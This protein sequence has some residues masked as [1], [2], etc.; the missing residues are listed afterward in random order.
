L[1]AGSCGLA[2]DNS[3]FAP[4]LLAVCLLLLTTSLPGFGAVTLVYV[5]TNGA[6]SGTGATI[7]APVSLPRAQARVRELNTTMS[8]DIKVQLLPGT[9]PITT[10]LTFNEN[11]S[12]SN[13]FNV[14]WCAQDTNNPPILSGGTNVTG[15]S[16]VAGTSNLW[17]APVTTTAFRQ[18][19]LNG[20]RRQR[21]QSC[22]PI[23]VRQ[24]ILN[25]NNTTRVLLVD[26]ATLPASLTAPGRAEIHVVNDWRDY[27]VALTAA[28]PTNDSRYEYA[29][30]ALIAPGSQWGDSG[31]QVFAAPNLAHACYLENA[32][33]LLDVP[34]EW[35][36]DAVSNRLYYMA[37]PGEDLTTAQ[38]VIPLVQALLNVQGSRSTKLVHNIEF[39]GLC[40]EY[41]TWTAV[42]NAGFV[43]IQGPEIQR[44]FV[45]FTPGGIQVENAAFFAFRNCRF[46]HLGATA[47]YCI[48]YVSDATI[49]GNAFTD[50]AGCGLQ[51]GTHYLS[52]A[53][54]LPIR[55][56]IADNLFYRVGRDYRGSQA[57]VAYSLRD[58]TFT[59]NHIEDVPYSGIQLGDF[60][61]NGGGY[62]NTKAIND[63]GNNLLGSNSVRNF[64]N[65]C[66]D[67]GAFYING[68]QN[69]SD[70]VQRTSLVTDNVFQEA[71]IDEGAL[72]SEDDSGNITYQRNVCEQSLNI[73][74]ND[75]I[76]WLYA[77]SPNSYNLHFGAG[78]N[79]NYA[80]TNMPG[81][82][83]PSDKNVPGHGYVAPTLYASP[84]ARPSAAAAIVAAA[85]L[86]PA[87]T[88][89]LAL[90]ANTNGNTAPTVLGL[91]NLTCDLSQTL[92][93]APT[94]SDDGLP[95]DR[96][97]TT[98]SE[99]SGPGNVT[100]SSLSLSATRVAFSAAGTYVLNFEVTDGALATNARFS[101]VVAPFTFGSNVVAG[102]LPTV[103]ASYFSDWN[104]A[105]VTDGSFSTD[106][107]TGIWFSGYGVG[108]NPWVQLDAGRAVSPCR[109]VLGARNGNADERGNFQI[110]AAN[111]PDFTNYVILAE[112]GLDPYGNMARWVANVSTTNSFRYFRAQSGNG[113][114]S[115][116]EFQV[117]ERAK[118]APP[119]LAIQTVGPSLQLTWSKGALLEATN[120]A[121]PWTTNTS[122]SPYLIAPNSPAKFYRIRWP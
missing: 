16:L 7:G 38:V 49:V 22:L 39:N 71:W 11:D 85:G 113:E 99:A 95:F 121:G 9:Y 116:S 4:V 10:T 73:A 25:T 104:P 52:P 60:N 27:F 1:T 83:N 63:T 67:G 18:L 34:A 87:Y 112:Q 89:L 82:Y 97:V 110:R 15:W 78:T 46:A 6:A 61:L 13:G 90:L 57:F 3:T 55:F 70:G 91:N 24:V 98:W 115:A 2:R 54:G 72:Y 111:T 101:V 47:L 41:S 36:A 30:T 120:V 33:E 109:F 94:V 93:L 88:N 5:A 96:L 64:S 107:K 79:A 105:S 19:Y 119:T 42:N 59:H 35:Y 62:N 44:P 56:T 17:S 12:G 58:S 103:S 40:F 114:F 26:S 8:N 80:T 51:V 43:P 32:R 20:E 69:G 84:A 21:A 65:F 106:Y 14:V 23:E 76:H 77:W 53:S 50:L 28:Y 100:F 117:F 108:S 74:Y 68:S 86:E 66:R 48:D 122:A 92:S 75:Q 31:G 81:Y 37:K 45:G 102:A 29:L 118:P